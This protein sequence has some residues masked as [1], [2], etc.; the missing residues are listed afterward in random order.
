MT[1]LSNGMYRT[2]IAVLFGV[3]GFGFNFLDIEIF[4]SPE[5][6]ISILPGLFFPLTIALAWGWRYGLLSA[7]TGGCQ[8]MWWL[9]YSDGWGVFYSVPVFTLWIVWHGWWADHRR[10]TDPWYKSAFTVEI[11]FRM[12]MELGFFLV[13]P[14]LVSNNPPPWDTG[15][16]WQTVS[17]SWIHTIAIKHVITGYILLSCAYTVLHIGCVRKFFHLIPRPA[18]KDTNAILTGAL[19]TG[20]AVWTSVSA[21]EFFA[22]NPGSRPFMDILI[23]KPEGHEAFMK[24]S[25]VLMCF[26]GAMVFA[27]LNQN[28][29]L[30]SQQL[31]HQNRILKAIRSINKLIKHEKN[32]N[33]LLDQT[34]RLLVSTQGYFNAWIV[35][36]DKDRPVKPFFH[37]GINADFQPMARALDNG[38]IPWCAEHALK[39]GDIYFAGNPVTQCPDCPLS[40][41]YK[42]RAGLA[43]RLAEDDKIFGWICISLPRHFIDKPSEIFLLTEVANEIS[44]A[45]YTIAIGQQLEKIEYE[46]MAILNS[47]KDAVVAFDMEYLITVFN[48]GAEK[49]FQCDKKEA[50]GT[51]VKRFCPKDKLETLD[52]M[53]R[54]VNDEGAVT[55]YETAIQN[56]SGQRVPVE[57]SLSLTHDSQGQAG[58]INA[59]IRDISDRRQ[60]EKER[61]QLESRLQQAQKM[62]SIGSLASGIAHDFNNILFPIMGLSEMMMDDFPEHNQEHKNACQIYTAGQRGSELIKQILSFSRQSESRPIPVRIQNILKEVIKLCRSSIPKDID[63]THEIKQDCRQVMADP[64]QIHQIA[65]NLITNAYHAVESTSGCISLQ[66]SEVTVN[67]EDMPSFQIPPGDYALLNVSDNGSGIDPLVINKIFDP[68]FTTKKKGKGT[69]LGLATVYGIVKGHGGDIKVYSEPGQGARFNIYLP[70]MADSDHL[71]PETQQLPLPSGDEHILLVDDENPIVQLEKQI[72]ERLGYKIT[73]FTSSVKALDAFKADPLIYDLII[74]D[75]SMPDLNGKQL[76]EKISE[77]TRDVPIIMCTGF[78]EEMG[79]EKA[80]ALG[81]KGFLMKPVVMHDIADLVRKILDDAGGKK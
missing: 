74:T 3:T 50:K 55:A 49:L 12:V 71:E 80:K 38:K 40:C 75:M 56:T 9:W 33:N 37:H 64:T 21:V 19:L 11:P 34:C 26:L 47:T 22:F 59:I 81:I 27:R 79:N 32:Q 17:P 54:Y 1:I 13:F 14:L 60:E 51:P 7:L 23:L 35:L 5:F 28:K 46:H 45:L 16:T 10:E 29:A 44:R 30:M 58:G 24:T 15:I 41:N 2:L 8:T 62:E 39:T 77:I 48:P 68:Y 65:M 53:L 69:G 43:A 73:A 20:L 42:D 18:Q 52:K 36:L 4:N 76:S 25:Y 31:S 72:L 6:K 66:L 78:S 57:I 67:R 63:I 70:L 61:K